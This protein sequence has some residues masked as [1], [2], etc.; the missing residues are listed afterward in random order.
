MTRSEQP[1]RRQVLRTTA[2]LGVA[3]TGLSVTGATAANPGNG[4]ERGAGKEFGRVYA[5]DVLWRT[6]V[7]N[8]LDER[9]DPED[10]IYFLHDGNGPIVANEKVSA[11]QLSPFVSESAPGDRD[12]N[13]GQWT[14]FSAAVTDIGAFN[15]DA[16]LTSDSDILDKDYIN[17]TLGRPGFGPPDFFVC[18]LNGRA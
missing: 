10:K 5:N 11:D 15:D 6:N 13:G 7:V 9:P 8:V 17:V 2:A 1:T 16:P 4:D 12:W 3:G 14:H 18:P